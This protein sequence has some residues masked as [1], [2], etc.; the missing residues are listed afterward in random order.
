MPQV[1]VRRRLGRPSGTLG[2]RVNRWFY[3]HRPQ[4]AVIAAFVVACLLG[5]AA[6][7]IG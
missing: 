7:T 1:I 4:V 5:M 2:H 3:R 6:V